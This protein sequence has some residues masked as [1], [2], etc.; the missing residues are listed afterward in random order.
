MPNITFSGTPTPILNHLLLVGSGAVDFQL[1]KNDLSGNGVSVMSANAVQPL[2]NFALKKG[3][4]RKG[5]LRVDAKTFEI[6]FTNLFDFDKY[7]LKSNDW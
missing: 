7:E 5:F 2:S 4:F 6:T 1:V 3:N